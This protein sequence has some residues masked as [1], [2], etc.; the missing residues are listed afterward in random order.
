[1]FGCWGLLWVIFPRGGRAGVRLIRWSE[2]IR[3]GVAIMSIRMSEFFLF[4]FSFYHSFLFFLALS[5][6]ARARNMEAWVVVVRGIAAG[7]RSTT[8]NAAMQFR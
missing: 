4:P 6:V 2:G 7:M 8:S 3:L 1:M 5:M